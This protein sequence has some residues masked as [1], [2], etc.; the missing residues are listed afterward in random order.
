M[1]GGEQKRRGLAQQSFEWT[2]MISRMMD[3]KND[4]RESCSFFSCWCKER[5]RR[6]KSKSHKRVFDASLVQIGCF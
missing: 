6:A 2:E 5:N 1:K 3:D 4:N